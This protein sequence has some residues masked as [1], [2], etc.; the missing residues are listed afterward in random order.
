MYLGS[1]VSL[2][3][4][5]KEYF[6]SGGMHSILQLD[7]LHDVSCIKSCNIIHEGNPDMYSDSKHCTNV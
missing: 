7:H 1:C 2:M 4:P 3:H 5:S 6:T